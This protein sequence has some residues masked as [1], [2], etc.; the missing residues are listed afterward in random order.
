MD[1]RMA[2]LGLKVGS[3][4]KAEDVYSSPC[5]GWRV[6]KT[7]PEMGNIFPKRANITCAFWC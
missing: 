6:G 4:L 2:A 1:R 5:Q 7:I 3:N